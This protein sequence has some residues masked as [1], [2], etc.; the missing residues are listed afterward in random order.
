[1]A[2]TVPHPNNVK[3]A[4]RSK[5]TKERPRIMPVV[6]QAQNRAMQAAAA[7]KSTLGIPKSVGEEFTSDLGPGDVKALPKRARKPSRADRLR[8]A[9]RI[10]D[11]QHA[12]MMK[13][14]RDT[15]MDEV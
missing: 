9:G 12:K 1:M 6:S 4:F 3:I 8:D 10:S 7:G 13:G 5:A 14:V 2:E 15:D 11:K